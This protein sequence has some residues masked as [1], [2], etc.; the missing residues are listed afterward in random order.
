MNKEILLHNIKFSW[1]S[2]EKNN[3]DIHDI[4]HIKKSIESGYSSGELC[5]SFTDYNKETNEPFNNVIY[6]WW[7]I[8]K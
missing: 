8:V 3:L 5:Q 6:G 7:E 2:G 1:R 4:E